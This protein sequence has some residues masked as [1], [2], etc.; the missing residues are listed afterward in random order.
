MSQMT[1][2][3]FC[4]VLHSHLPW[5]AHHG[6]WPIGEEW[7]HQAWADSYA[8]VL[9]VVSTLANE[10]QRDLLTLGITPVLAAALDDPYCLQEHHRWLAD[11][12]WRAT[13]LSASSKPHLQDAAHHEITY[14]HKALA[15]FERR[16]KH[17]ASP[18]LRTLSDLK[19]IEILGG[20]LSH[21]FTPFLPESFATATLNCG[22]DDAQ[23]RLGTRPQG[24]WT[25]ECAYTP[26]LDA[27]FTKA[28]VQH[29]MLEGPTLQAQ[30]A[31]TSGVYQLGDSNIRVLGRD[32]EATYR[33]WSPRRGYPGNRWYRDFH[34]FD[35][36]A[37]LRL[38]RVTGR[39]V[40]PA[41]KAPYDPAQAASIVERDARDFVSHVRERLRG[42]Q[43][44]NS[45]K[46]GIVVAAFD[47]E[48]FGH[49]WH[50]GPQWL[51]HVL[52]L[53][54]VAG[55]ALST[56]A[57]AVAN[58]DVAGTV[59]PDAGSWG[60]GKDFRVWSGE[61]T[62]EIRARYGKAIDNALSLLRNLQV[63]SPTRARD[64]LLDQLITSLL[65][66]LSSD[67]VFLI[68]KQGAAQ[69]ARERIDGHLS[70]VAFLCRIAERREYRSALPDDEAVALRAIADRDRIWGHLDS[71]RFG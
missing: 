46:P 62:R 23:L 15:N 59:H 40:D 60:S 71:R 70:D 31:N 50:E 20:P 58:H 13:A 18:I 49:W 28:N 68:E 29:L 11:R 51:E 19:A 25:P 43:K 26:E 6:T 17:G 21:T 52:R 34:T 69:Y 41:D 24:I 37:G 7:L 10:G 64:E 67:W 44:D 61:S 16:W 57:K 22:L 54:P 8:P 65:L 48:L 1:V 5:V 66:A 27:V 36:E 3:T 53:M 30:G 12:Y 45:G 32:L 9:D 2:G 35:H 33:V 55:I 42:I 56:L 47:T 63:T 4:L 14:A 38:S 39:D